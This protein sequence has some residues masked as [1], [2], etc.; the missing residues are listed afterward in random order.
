MLVFHIATPYVVGYMGAHSVLQQFGY[1][2]HVIRYQAIY[3]NT[4][5][6][7]CLFNEPC[8]YNYIF[9]RWDV[10]PR[11]GRCFLL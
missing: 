6:T 8:Y 1:S 9:P 11:S 4:L 5:L 3:F 2:C 10:C 7:S